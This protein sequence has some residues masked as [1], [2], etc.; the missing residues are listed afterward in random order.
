MQKKE[1]IEDNYYIEP[2]AVLRMR[3]ILTIVIA[4]YK[5]NHCDAPTK[6]LRSNFIYILQWII[7]K[8]NNCT[9]II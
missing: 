7:V 6:A 1:W 8:Y 3:A 9:H 5:I 4:F 2:A